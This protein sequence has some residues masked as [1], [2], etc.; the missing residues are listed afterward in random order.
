MRHIICITG[1]AEFKKKTN[2]IPWLVWV[3]IVC[4]LP[5]ISLAPY[6]ALFGQLVCCHTQFVQLCLPAFI[7]VLMFTLGKDVFVLS[8]LL[9]L[10]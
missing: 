10:L 7:F 3:T 4:S 2:S 5:F 8:C 1:C 6:L 9:L